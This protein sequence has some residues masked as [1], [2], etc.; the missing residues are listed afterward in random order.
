MGLGVEKNE[1]KGIK[2]FK[3]AGELGFSD[4][5]NILGN[6]FVKKSTKEDNLIAKK[7]FKK[8]IDLNDPEGYAHMGNL[9]CL[10]QEKNIEIAK[11]YYN[12]GMFNGNPSSVINL[13]M[14]YLNESAKEK[15]EENV[16]INKNLACKIFEQYKEYIKD[17]KDLY[18]KNCSN[19]Q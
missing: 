4:A 14:Y 9:Y 15:D 7:Y 17:A 1:K 11:I 12:L 3:K 16:K 18:K 6:Y 2:Y 10:D 13:G 19:E 8:A 5:Y